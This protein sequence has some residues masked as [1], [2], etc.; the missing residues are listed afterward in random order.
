MASTLTRCHPRRKE[1]GNGDRRKSGNRA[2]EYVDAP[3]LKVNALVEGSILSTLPSYLI[4]A[5]EIR[6]S[7]LP[8]YESMVRYVDRAT[9]EWQRSQDRVP[10]GKVMKKSY[11]RFSVRAGAGRGAANGELRICFWS[12]NKCGVSIFV[13][14]IP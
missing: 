10:M 2:I 14:I 1:K 13:S 9:H 5:L 12:D 11:L 6:L 7:F 3:P 8:K 4:S